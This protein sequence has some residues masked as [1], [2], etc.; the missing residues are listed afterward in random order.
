MVAMPIQC[1]QCEDAPCAAACPQKAISHGAYF[2]E[3]NQEL[4]NGCKTCL[5]VCPFGAMDVAPVN[6]QAGAE[7]Q[8]GLKVLVNGVLEEKSPYAAVKCDLCKGR[9]EG[10][11]CVE[12]CPGK[13][14]TIVSEKVMKQSI[15]QRQVNSAL[16][17]AKAA[18]LL[19][20]PPSPP[21]H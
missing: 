12:I 17:M 5:L 18:D 9:P 3:V 19:K 20:P 14:F 10:P 2:V 1:R 16:D 15:K 4:C 13:A 21:A 11:A 7:A 8:K 6:Q